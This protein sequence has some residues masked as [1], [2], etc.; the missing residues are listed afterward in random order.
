MVAIVALIMCPDAASASSGHEGGGAP[1]VS[2]LIFPTINFLLFVYLLRRAGGGAIRDILI[3]RREEI[4]SALRA[5]AKAKE[6]AAGAYEEAR[7]QLADL[8]RDAMRLREEMRGVAE[9]ERS[10]RLK[11]AT[12]VAARI[13]RDARQV[14]D[15]EVRAARLALREETV[16]AA[17]EQTIAL[18]RRQIKSGDQERFLGEF[19]AEVQAQP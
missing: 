12:E 17:S 5:G 19:A 6:D 8:P 2:D 15:Q 9:A 1:S 11:V 16:R 18:L 4:V 7:L 13:S 14:A 10:R 3:R